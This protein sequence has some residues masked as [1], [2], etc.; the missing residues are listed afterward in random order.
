MRTR[1][2]SS[3]TRSCMHCAAYAD[4]TPATAEFASCSH[5]NKALLRGLYNTVQQYLRHLQC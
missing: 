2:V 1:S 5:E 3:A 4:V